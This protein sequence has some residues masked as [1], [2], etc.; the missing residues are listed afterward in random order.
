MSDSISE[1]LDDGGALMAHHDRAF[2]VPITVADM[3]VGVADPGG[4]HPDADLARTR[5]DELERLDP[6][7]D[8]RPV[9]NGRADRRGIAHGGRI[10]RRIGGR[11]RGPAP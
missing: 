10:A 3:E 4:G 8:A 1:R 6:G 2:A 7:R 9:E 11:R 5:R